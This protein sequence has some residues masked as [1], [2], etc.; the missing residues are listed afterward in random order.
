[1][2]SPLETNG[3]A[4]ASCREDDPVT[5]GLRMTVAQASVRARTGVFVRVPMCARAHACAL[6]I[7][8]Y[9]CVNA[10]TYTCVHVCVQCVCV[11]ICECVH[12][13][14]AGAMERLRAGSGHSGS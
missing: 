8:V 6:R 13:R 11:H 14:V 12:V 9:M 5:L 1:M 2:T 10:C 3:R 7:S 4:A